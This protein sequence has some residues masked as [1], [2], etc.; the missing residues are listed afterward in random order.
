MYN[1]VH[2]YITFF[3][4]SYNIINI[5]LQCQQEGHYFETKWNCFEDKFSFGKIRLIRETYEK[6]CDICGTTI[7]TKRIKFSNK[8]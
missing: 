7:K 3:V 5:K 2:F 4:H 6:T 1:I 8:K